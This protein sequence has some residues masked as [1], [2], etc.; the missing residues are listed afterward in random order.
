[1]TMG[2]LERRRMMGAQTFSMQTPSCPPGQHWE[3]DGA[4]PIRGLAA[5]VPDRRV[6]LN[7]RTTA[8]A[9]P[10]AAPVETVSLPDLV[11]PTM[12]LAPS[13]D[14]S[15]A[16]QYVSLPDRAAAPAP[17]PEPW[18]WWWML[19]AAAAGGAAAYYVGKNP[20]KTKKNVGHA[21]NAIGGRIVHRAT[22]AAA[23]RLF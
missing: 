8:P 11:L 9:A 15:P 13:N 5:C 14:A 4:G 10:P 18:P 7:F 16:P 21:V 2:Q 20:K 6:T 22:N 1:M 17:C 23:A 12:K 19:V 3:D